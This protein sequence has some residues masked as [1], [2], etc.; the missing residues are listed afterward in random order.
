MT[1]S[2]SDVFPL[3]GRAMDAEG[4]VEFGLLCLLVLAYGC[5]ESRACVDEA[6]RVERRAGG[7]V[8]VCYGRAA[9]MGAGLRLHARSVLQLRVAKRAADNKLNSPRRSCHA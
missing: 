9:V 5:T 6:A 3:A 4:R 8:T 2:L 1:V 7:M